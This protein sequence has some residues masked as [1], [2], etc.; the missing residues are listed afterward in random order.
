MN[1]YTRIVIINGRLYECIKGFYERLWVSNSCGRL[2]CCGTALLQEH[3]DDWTRLTT[4]KSTKVVASPETG[5]WMCD[6]QQN[7]I[8]VIAVVIAIVIAIHCQA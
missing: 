1:F 7:S 4:S 6:M 5:R 3:A 8:V 2:D